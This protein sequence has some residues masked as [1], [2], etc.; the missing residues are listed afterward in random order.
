MTGRHFALCVTAVISSACV[1]DSSTVTLLVRNSCLSPVFVSWNPKV[2]AGLQRHRIEA[3]GQAR[4]HG[5]PQWLTRES[6]LSV[7]ASTT[8]EPQV[9]TVPALTDRTFELPSSACP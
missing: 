2:V 9:V 6:I 3:R 1:K 7:A 5:E 4:L 8:A